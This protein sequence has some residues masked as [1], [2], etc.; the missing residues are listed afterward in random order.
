M[1]VTVSVG[2]VSV[3]EFR[4]GARPKN[5][6]ILMCDKELSM[7][8]AK[9]AL[10][11]LSPNPAIRIPCPWSSLVNYLGRKTFVDWYSK[12]VYNPFDSWCENGRKVKGTTNK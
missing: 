6:K 3:T 4:R 5:T 10:G 7:V 9:P 12:A 11:V 1:T 8:R 2:L